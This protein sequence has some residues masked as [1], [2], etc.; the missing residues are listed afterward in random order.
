MSFFYESSQ[1]GK[2]FAQTIK[3]PLKMQIFRNSISAHDNL[4]KKHQTITIYELTG[5]SLT[6]HDKFAAGFEN[7]LEQFPF[8]SSP[9]RYRVTMPSMSGFESGTSVVE[10]QV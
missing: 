9:G 6:V 2:F 5:T 8:N 4:Y 10:N 1:N 7:W 3:R